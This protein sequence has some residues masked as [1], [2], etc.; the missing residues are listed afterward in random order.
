MEVPDPEDDNS[1]LELKSLSRNEQ[2]SI[3]KKGNIAVVYRDSLPP[4]LMAASKGDLLQLQA[5]ANEA[6]ERDEEKPVPSSTKQND[7]KVDNSRIHNRN[8]LRTLI[9]TRDRH[10]STADHW[11]SGGGHLDCLRYLYD[12]RTSLGTIENRTDC[13]I[14]SKQQEVG[15]VRSKTQRTRRR[16]GKTCLHYAARNGHVHCIRYLLELEREDRPQRQPDEQV[17]CRHPIHTVDERSGERTTPLHLACYGGHPEAVKYLVEN[18]GADALSKNDWGCTCAHWVAM[19]I[20]ES[21]A[22]VRE[23]CSYL[24]E[25]CRVS[26]VEKQGHGHTALHKAAHRRNRHII[27][28]MADPRSIGGPGLNESDKQKAGAPDLGGHKPSDIWK[29]MGGDSAFAEWMKT[30]G[31]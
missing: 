29:N 28:W 23:I 6:E 12:L 1:K 14:R 30:L 31:W 15:I 18:H 19:T 26:F 7:A 25:D 16:D 13:K 24:A 10:N 8:H 5:L 20:S 2:H 11:A 9:N 3:D 22:A 4:F 21:E 17:H 27:Q